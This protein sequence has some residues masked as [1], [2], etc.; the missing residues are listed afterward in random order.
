MAPVPKNPWPQVILAL[1]LA[2]ILVSGVV[3]LLAMDKS[4][5]EILTVAAL[6]AGPALAW[7]ATNNNQK[8]DQLKEIGNGNLSRRDTQSELQTA[9]L[10]ALNSRLLA[11]VAQTHQGIPKDVAEK[12]MA[13]LVPSPA[14]SPAPL[15]VPVSPAAA[16]ALGDWASRVAP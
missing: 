2:L 14:P 16:T 7:F 6:V 5:T 8:L 1:G 10:V 4:V 13:A 3:V 12:L 9:Q 11:L 15:P